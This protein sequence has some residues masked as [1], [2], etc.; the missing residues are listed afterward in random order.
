MKDVRFAGGPATIQ[1]YVRAG[2]VGELHLAIV[3][4]LAGSGERLLDSL[5]DGI[6]GYQVAERISSAAATH[7]RLIRR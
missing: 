4:V 5:G 3:P 1:Q 6:D 7:A 2:L